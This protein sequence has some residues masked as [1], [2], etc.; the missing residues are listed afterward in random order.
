MHKYNYVLNYIL[1]KMFKLFLLKSVFIKIK[2]YK[3]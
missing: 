1:F 2:E 3:F